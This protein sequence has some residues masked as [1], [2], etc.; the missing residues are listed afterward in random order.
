LTLKNFSEFVFKNLGCTHIRDEESMHSL[1][2]HSGDYLQAWKSLAAFSMT[3]TESLHAFVKRD[4]GQI[5]KTKGDSL[6]NQMK[7]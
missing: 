3:G 5:G 4:K 7:K 2:F 1:C 6:K